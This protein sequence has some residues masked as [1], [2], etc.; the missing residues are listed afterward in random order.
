MLIPALLL[1]TLAQAPFSTD[2]NRFAYLD[3]LDPYYVSL[4]FP[5][6]E[7]PQ[8]IGEEG[9]DAAIFLSIDD[10]RTHE[11]YEEFLRPVLERLKQIDGRAPVTIFTNFIE[12]DNPHVQQWLG[13]GLH[14]DVHTVKHPCPLLAGGDFSAAKQTVDECVDLLGRIPN[15][16][17]VAYRMP[18]CDSQNTMSPRFLQEIF[19]KTTPEQRFL[20]V[21]SSVFNLT[22]ANDPTLPRELVLHEDGRERFRKYVPFPRFANTIEDYPYPYVIGNGALEFPCAVPSDWAAQNLNKPN[23]PESLEI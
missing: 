7:T 18:C 13:E 1:A 6:L 10:M 12:T 22:T 5:R 23:A 9:V 16:S 20:S 19:L 17:A 15:H 14:L 21:D 4:D 11:N 2:V 8:W 3:T